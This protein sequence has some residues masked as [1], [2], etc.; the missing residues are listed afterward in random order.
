MIQQKNGSSVS[1]DTSVFNHF[2]VCEDVDAKFFDANG[3][4]HLVLWVVSGGNEMPS[5]E[6]SN[7]DRLFLNDGTGH[8][9][10]SKVHSHATR[11]ATCTV[12]D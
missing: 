1:C 4:G 6:I 8:L 2:A 11:K 5:N 9:K 3:D 7:A 10:F 12:A